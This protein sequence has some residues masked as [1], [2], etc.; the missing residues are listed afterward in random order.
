MK[1]KM[2]V[3][4]TALSCHFEGFQVSFFSHFNII[5]KIIYSNVYSI[6]LHINSDHYL[7]SFHAY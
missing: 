2:K 3:I 1:N 5:K 4:P 6:I 7:T